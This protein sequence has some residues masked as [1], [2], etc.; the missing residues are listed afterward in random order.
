MNKIHDLS[1]ITTIADFDLFSVPPTQLTIEKNIITEHRPLS[2]LNPNS[3]IEFT[4]SSAVD[5]YI[6]LRETTLMMKLRVDI[7]KAAAAAA[8]VD[9]DD[10]KKIQ[11]VNNLLHSLFKTVDL[12]IEGKSVTQSP[13]TYAYKAYF[14]TLLGYADEAKK[15]HLSGSMW[16]DDSKDKEAVNEDRTSLITPNPVAKT[17]KMIELYGKLHLDLAFQPRALLGGTKL[18]ITLVPNDKSFYLW[19]NG[20]T[21]TTTVHWESA[22]LYITR[23]KLAYPIVEAQ[24]LALTRG[25]AKYPIMRGVVKSFNI[26]TGS[27]D[28]N[29]DNAI[30]GQIPRRMFLALVHSSGF[31]GVEADNPY[32]FQHFNL[33]HLIASVDGVQYPSIAFTPNFTNDH[34]IREYMSVFETLNQVTTDSCL[35]L[36]KNDYKKG[37]VIYGFSFSPDPVDD[38][39]KSGYVNPISHGSIRISMK[40]SAAPTHNINALLYCEYDNM[41][42]I[43]ATRQPYCDYI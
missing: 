21:L 23:S 32:R 39:N 11:P 17:G 6:Q 20:A 41:I 13:R 10:W 27:L 7:A 37:N 31:N 35:T 43:D 19:Q 26:P 24:N 4:V 8:A 30:S 15:G 34:Y 33:N 40:F 42:Q 29:F 28:V 38:C 18:K 3:I 12:E 36:S 16:Y 1:Q 9:A 5:E 14:E 25:S 22:A 2:T